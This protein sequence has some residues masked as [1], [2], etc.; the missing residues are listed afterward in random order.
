MWQNAFRSDLLKNIRVISN[1]FE[2]QLYINDIVI[3]CVMYSCDMCLEYYRRGLFKGITDDTIDDI[4]YNVC[5]AMNGIVKE[6]DVKCWGE[7][8]SKV[9]LLMGDSY[10][11]NELQKEVDRYYGH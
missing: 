11:Y 7:V 8:M 3:E 2:K 1:N 9:N 10:T 6:F 5:V 4:T